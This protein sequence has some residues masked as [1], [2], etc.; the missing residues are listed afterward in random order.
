MAEII[1]DKPVSNTFRPSFFFW[2]T[3]VMSGFIFS[4]FGITYWRPM[5]GGSLAPLPPIVHI[6]G[7]L[8]SGW[9]L[10]LMV[11]SFLVNV[12]N[13]KL[14]RSLGTFGI[15]MAT[16]IWIFAVMMTILPSDP[17]G[18]NTGGEYFSLEYLSVSAFVLFGV[19]FCLAIRN[20]RTPASHRRYILFSIIPLLP[21]GINRLYMSLLEQF[22]L[23][24]V[25]TYLTMDA[26]VAAI[27][28]QDWRE[29][30]KPGRASITG[31]VLII[32]THL[33]HVPISNSGA[34]AEFCMFLGSLSG[35]R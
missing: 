31:A 22:T 6:H 28:I 29:N 8:F 33:L 23:P 15:S 25:W 5:A 3:V 27:V 17:T 26:M 16:L 19:L 14:H 1:A 2:M 21:P 4:G 30:G 9:M 32:G 13:I 24:L 34:F 35:Y 20:V 18:H 10:L 7:F 12:K 11:Q